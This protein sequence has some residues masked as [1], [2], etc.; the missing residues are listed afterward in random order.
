MVNRNTLE[1][2]CVDIYNDCG[3]L[4]AEKVPVEGLDPSRNHAIANMLYE[5]K[6]TV[7]IDLDK[8]QKSLRTGELGGEYCRLPHYA[9]PDIAI[10]DRAER[11]RDRV[12]SFVRISDGD[13]TRVELFDKGK[14]L[15]IQLPKPIMEVSAD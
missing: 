3:K 14:R 5:M 15:L 7:V 12:E 4:V 11:I 9:I 8:V 2:E 1:S 6:R 13:D 10:L